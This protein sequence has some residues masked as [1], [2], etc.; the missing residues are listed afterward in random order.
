MP[1]VAYFW[2]IHQYAV[3]VVYQDQWA[4]IGLLGHWYQGTLNLSDLWASHG[5][6]RM[7]FPNLIVIAL[8]Q[9]TRFNVVFEEYLSGVMLVA[10]AVL[11]ISIHR[12][13]APSTPMIY[14]TPVTLL[15]FSFVQYQ[16]TL[17]GFQMAWYL[18]TLALALTLFFLDRPALTSWVFVGA[19]AATVIGSF[20]SLQG[21]LIWPVGLLV[22]YFRRRTRHFLLIWIVCA[23]TTA[24]VYF[25][26]LNPSE[27]SNQTYLFTHPIETVKFFLFLIGSVL[28]VELSHSP[29]PIIAFGAIIM[30]MAIVLVVTYQRGSEQGS[31][32]V[33]V[34]LICYG[35]LFAATVT[36]GRAWFGLWAPSR[37]AT[38]GLLILV[39]CYLVVLERAPARNRLNFQPAGAEDRTERRSVIAH[40]VLWVGL[41]GVICIQVIFGTAH[42]L[43]SAKSWSQSQKEVADITVNI[44]KASNPLLHSEIVKGSTHVARQL[45]QIA[46]VYRL[47][48]FATGAVGQYS[49]A[50]LLPELTA[51]RVRIIV[52]RRGATLKGTSVLDAIASDLS[53]VTDVD[54][55]LTGDGVHDTLIGAAQSTPYGW[56]ATFKT[57]NYPNGSYKLRSVAH[58]YG[59]ETSSSPNVRITLENPP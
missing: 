9:F 28:G 55:R 4:D 10:A 3:N 30:V 39:G 43:T 16:N 35:V 49:R 36:E 27:Y 45:V 53:G 50:G 11:F 56:V 54:F 38:C 20:S 1:I 48:L 58:G 34:A 40:T 21:L 2:F 57:T 13:H 12:R 46:K 24:T 8:A 14:Y 19:I 15:L 6:H 31:G 42:A 26:Q 44:D 52:P 5:D 18:V 59:G 47:S 7:L 41:A 23:L 29:W 25:Y 33:G 37:Y 32:L 17:W 51:L 22:L